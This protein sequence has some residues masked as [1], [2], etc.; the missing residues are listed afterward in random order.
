MNNKFSRISALFV[1]LVL[2]SPLSYSQTKIAAHVVVTIGKVE[3]VRA[4]GIR[5]ALQRRDVISAGDTVETPADGLV[6]LRFVDSALVALGCASK[7][8]VN[9]YSY[10]QDDADQAV[11]ILLAGNLRTVAGEIETEKYRLR[12]ADTVVRGGDGDFEVAI[13]PDDTQYFAVYDGAMTII[14]SQNQTKL[15][16]GASADFGKLEPGFQFEELTQYPPVLGLAI[17]N[18]TDCTN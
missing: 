17:L 5:E 13:A 4:S 14:D 9:S 15:G 7:L 10:R 12:M 2:I 18:I 6:Q 8:R 1:S 3:V 16:A 11:L